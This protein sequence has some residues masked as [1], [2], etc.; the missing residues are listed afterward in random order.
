M[1]GEGTHPANRAARAALRGRL[2]PALLAFVGGAGAFLL[3][4][5]D[6][7]VPRG[8]LWGG[9]CMVACVLGLM[10]LLGY[11]SPAPDARALSEAPLARQPGEHPLLA[12]SR[13]LPGALALVLAVALFLGGGA[14]PP[15]IVLMLAW[16]LPAA[17][18]RP[19]LLVFVLASAIHLPLLGDFGLW[20]P[21]ETHYGEVAREILSRDD[22]ISLWWAQDRWFW[23]KPI[24]IFWSEAL[25]WSA[26]GIDFLPDSQFRHTEWVLRLPI[27][28]VASTALLSIYT[29]ISR[30]F[31][32]RAG[33]LS[34]LVL[35]TTPYFAFLS[36]QAITDMPFVG[37]MTV[38]LMIFLIA[39][40][41]DPERPTVGYRIGR[42]GVSLRE[43]SV[44][45]F[46]LIALPQAL[47]LASRN[48]TFVGGLFAWHGDE[49]MYGSGHNPDVPGNFGI[50]D[51]V[52]WGRALYV[53]PLAQALYWGLGM[54]AVLLVHRRERSRQGFLMLGFYIACGL[55][56]MAKG[57][58]GFALPGA[59]A[60]LYLIACGRFP[61]LFDGRFR[62]GAGALALTTLS[63][64]WFVAMFVRHG[65]AFTDRLLIHDHLNR[66]T[67]GVHGDKGSIDY[68][69]G[70]LGYGTFPWF[71]LFPL[72]LGAF[73]VMGRSRGDEPRE[74]MQ[75]REVLIVLGLWFAAAFT[76]FSAMTTK[77]HHYIFPAVPP[78]A[79]L[80]GLLVDEL[81]GPEPER[82]PL[83]RL[84]LWG[85]SALAPLPLVL[86]FA[87]LYGAPRGILPP[88]LSM[89]ERAVWAQQHAWP[90]GLCWGLIAVGLLS[91]GSAARRY[92]RDRP[93]PVAASTRER[94][95]GVGLLGCA[96]L[97]AFVGR[98]LSWTTA[99]RPAGQERLAQLFIYNYD[100]PFPGDF[101]YRPILTGFT[102]ALVLLLSL[103]ALRVTRPVLMRA[104]VGLS[105]VFT[106]W[107]VDVYMI[108]LTPHWSQRGLI[109]RYYRE[110]AGPEEPLV[111]WQMN[112]KGENYYTGN[113][114]AVFVQ[115]NSKK[116]EKWMEE[117]EGAT[118]YF[119]LEHKR[120]NRF[121]RLAKERKPEVLT[122]KRDNNKFLL[123]RMKL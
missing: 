44:F 119:L 21:W 74:Q 38:A 6:R 27:F 16:M 59:V 63:M 3:M 121:R 101:D 48:I 73:L 41:E 88:G 55:A 64:P 42:Y 5:N 114:V 90:S 71:G 4:A 34:A 85:L 84:R 50:R 122:S 67:K 53:Q 79:V 28:V 120:L 104:L 98:D 61:M 95:L 25:T 103:A 26:S 111:A 14:L 83:R 12:P 51:Q 22:W 20:D 30:R 29:A 93:P 18:R 19:G 100:R 23:S 15:A 82:G 75:R 17:L 113:R 58:P 99:E 7:Q 77:F 117:N 80:V 107:V 69:I 9:L 87:G 92:L 123:L 94:A 52:P 11:F 43:V 39:V 45:C 76:L 60:L 97:V 47:Y 68:F 10:R 106:L 13:V 89:A 91:L 2:Q 78:A 1:A 116:I 33:V 102:F 24:F 8:A 62:I 54:A 31:G 37:L 66:L 108:D 57:I 109:E 65:P 81:M 96:V 118:A 105:L 72:A 86:G 40:H 110:R 49:F 70:E 56:F 32:A 112:W 46:L 35:A 115:L 36:H